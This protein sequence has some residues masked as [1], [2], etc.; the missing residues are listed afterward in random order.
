[1]IKPEGNQVIRAKSL[2]VPIRPPQTPNRL[3]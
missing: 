3:A 2:P 1:M